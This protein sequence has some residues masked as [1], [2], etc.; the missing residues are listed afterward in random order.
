MQRLRR[1]SRPRTPR[2]RTLLVWKQMRARRSHS[3]NCPRLLS[4]VVDVVRV[5]DQT[6]PVQPNPLSV[7]TYSVSGMTPKPNSLP[8]I[9]AT[10]TKRLTLMPLWMRFYLG[11]RLGFP[12]LLTLHVL[13]IRY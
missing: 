5:V 11:M 2:L 3:A 7:S 12:H 8:M 9:F 1:H 4:L 6:I 13:S 10:H